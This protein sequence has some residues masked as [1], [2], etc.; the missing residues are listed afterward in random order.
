ME[1]FAPQEGSIRV[2]E[3]FDLDLFTRMRGKSLDDFRPKLRYVELQQTRLPVLDPESLIFLK[4]GSWREKD[5][6]DVRAMKE[7]LERERKGN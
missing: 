3:E 7:I 4:S 1:D 2:S 5:Q 6:L